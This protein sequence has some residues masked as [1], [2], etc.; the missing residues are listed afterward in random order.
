LIL[1]VGIRRGYRYHDKQL[2][3]KRQ[4]IPGK[5][6]FILVKVKDHKKRAV[7]K[8]KLIMS[9]GFVKEEDQEEVPIIPPR[10]DLPAGATNYVTQIGMDELLEEKELL[11]KERDRLDISNENERRIALN[12]INGKLQLLNNRIA[13]AKIIDLNKQPKEVV[14]FGAQVTL[15]T[16]TDNKLRK[17]QIVGVDEA[18]IAK[19]KI[20][21]LSPMAKI[22]IDKKEGDKATLKLAK[23]DR[24]FEIIKIVY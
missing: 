2:L 11:I 7:I 17:Y 20:S 16:G 5:C 19:G 14:R 3:L 10:A 8:I 6:L 23:E 13:T 22:L 24:I 9:R 18:D 15:K 1:D 4:K 12:F 21:F